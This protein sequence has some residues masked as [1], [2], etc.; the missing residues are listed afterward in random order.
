MS[1]YS[2]YIEHLP[3]I[4]NVVGSSPAEAAHFSL[5]MIVRGELH[6]V[7]LLWVSL[8]LIIILYLVPSIFGTTI[9]TFF[10]IL[11]KCFYTCIIYTSMKMSNDCIY[12]SM[13]MSN[14]CIY[15][16]LKM[17]NDCIYTS[18]KMSNDCI[19]TSMK[20]S[21]DYYI[22]CTSMKIM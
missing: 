9:P 10:N 13:K 21:N 18:M 19:Y 2:W 5:K 16:S 4:Q 11:M 17:S 12:T 3:R 22:I 20:M 15:T 6:C 7:F 8:G 1:A 14:D